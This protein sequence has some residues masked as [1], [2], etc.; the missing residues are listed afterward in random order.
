MI[1]HGFYNTDQGRETFALNIKQITDAVHTTCYSDVLHSLLSC[2]AYYKQWQRKFGVHSSRQSDILRQERRRWGIV[3]KSSR[4][5]YL[6]DADLKRE[7]R[8]EGVSFFVCCFDTHTHT[9]TYTHTHTHTHTHTQI[10]P[11]CWVWRKFCFVLV[12][13]FPWTALTPHPT[14]DRMSVYLHMNHENE[15]DYARRGPGAYEQL[16]SGKIQNTF[17]GLPVYT[18]YPLDVDFNGAPISLLE[19]DRQIGEWFYIRKDEDIRIFSATTDKFETITW[20]DAVA[21]DVRRDPGDP[22]QARLGRDRDFNAD[23]PILIFRPFQTWRMAS[24]LLLKSGS[25]LGNTFRKS[26][27][28]HCPPH[29]H[30]VLAVCSPLLSFPATPQNYR[31]AS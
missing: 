10:V 21:A 18:S 31:W 16:S 22:T 17:R 27:W 8:R 24:A 19:R 23:A 14:A 12:V 11:D 3:A 30:C 1:E 9:H 6:L 4:G 13:Y 7:F 5:M 26:R 29:S 20:D 28:L 2:D 15:V 25:E